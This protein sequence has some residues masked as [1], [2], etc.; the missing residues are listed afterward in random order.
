M[1]WLLP[2]FLLVGSLS[3]VCGQEIKR[4]KYFIALKKNEE[5]V[6]DTLEQYTPL[7][8]PPHRLYADP[9]LFKYQGL[10]Y[11]FFEDYDYQKGVIVCATIDNELRISRP[12][13]VLELDEHLSFPFVFEDAGRIYMT[14]ETIQS[15]EVALYEAIEFPQRW[16]KRKVLVKGKDFADPIVFRHNGY[17][18][19]FVAI[20]TSILQIYYAKT[21]FDPFKPHR[22]NTMRKEGRNAGGVFSSQGKLIRPVMDCSKVYGGAMILKEIVELTPTSFIEKDL[23]RIEPDWAPGLDGTHTFNINEDLVVY[24]GR[25]KVLSSE[26][27]RYSSSL[28]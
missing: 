21:L 10:N 8:P 15:K 28:E 26:D 22:I 27:A 14:P 16:E 7:L 2:F 12:I 18:W 24:D 20:D 9:M 23:R 6:L 19:L 13:K 3:N 25:R 17:Y 11:L 5:A 4:S 1:Y